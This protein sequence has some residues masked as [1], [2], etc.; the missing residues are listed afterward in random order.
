MSAADCTRLGGAGRPLLNRAD[1]AP[2]CSDTGCAER[3]E[4]AAKFIADDD[5]AYGCVRASHAWVW[6]AA[7][8]SGNGV[9]QGPNNR[10]DRVEQ[11]ARCRSEW[12][13]G[14]GL[15]LGSPR[16]GS[17]SRVS[18]QHPSKRRGSGNGRKRGETDGGSSSTRMR[19]TRIKIN[20]IIE[21]DK[22]TLIVVL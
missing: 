21:K 14:A 10:G 18:T 20:A 11:S 4:V 16:R 8:A 1:G 15:W 22:C 9:S 2:S 3:P 17:G 19:C 12:T 5:D 13:S 7:A 6:R